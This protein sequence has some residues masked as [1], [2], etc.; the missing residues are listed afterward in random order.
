M[1]PFYNPPAPPNP[2]ASPPW[3]K[4]EEED[5]AGYNCLKKIPTVDSINFTGVSAKSYH[6][7]WKNFHKPGDWSINAWY[8]QYKASGTISVY[9]GTGCTGY[10]GKLV[11]DTTTNYFDGYGYVDNGDGFKKYDSSDTL[12]CSAGP[13]DTYYQGVDPITSSWGCLGYTCGDPDTVSVIWLSSNEN[14]QTLWDYTSRS[15]GNGVCSWVGAYW[16]YYKAVGTMTQTLSYEDTSFNALENYAYRGG[17]GSEH[18]GNG[19]ILNAEDLNSGYV[20]GQ[21]C[22]ADVYVTGLCELRTY[23]LFADANE[24]DYPSGG[25]APYQFSIF[26]VFKTGPGDANEHVDVPLP[27]PTSPGRQV[28]LDVASVRVVKAPTP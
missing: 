10:G 25:G 14:H 7:G 21:T 23:W 22:T 5:E 15:I 17:T 8:T 24:S 18:H 6:K 20:D 13:H 3:K 19:T 4:R 2:P 16:N 26:E 11:T 9:A 12:V 27:M 1:P 28:V